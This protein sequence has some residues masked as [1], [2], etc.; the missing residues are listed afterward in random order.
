MLKYVLSLVLTEVPNT[1][2]PGDK[3]NWPL[4]NTTGVQLLVLNSTFNA[5]RNELL[6][7]KGFWGGVKHF[8]KVWRVRIV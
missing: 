4:Y 8:G 1:L 3:I 2:W 7:E 6:N 5:A